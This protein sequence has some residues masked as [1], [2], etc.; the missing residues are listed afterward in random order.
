MLVSGPYVM[1]LDPS[2]MHLP[3]RNRGGKRTALR[4]TLS[5]LARSVNSCFTPV[6]AHFLVRRKYPDQ[7][8]AFKSLF[9]F[10]ISEAEY[11]GVRLSSALVLYVS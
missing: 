7:I 2:G 3:P 1:M 5:N 8:S 10:S 9:G 4:M 6:E 11:N